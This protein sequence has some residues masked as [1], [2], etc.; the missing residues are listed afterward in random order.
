MSKTRSASIVL[1][2]ALAGTVAFAPSANAASSASAVVV[3]VCSQGSQAQL[4]ASSSGGSIAVDF[5]VSGAP[6]GHTWL[7]AIANRGT[8]VYHGAKV[9]DA[10]GSWSQSGSTRNKVGVDVVTGWAADLSTGEVCFALKTV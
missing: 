8:V 5:S 2:T 7:A 1:A 3:T 10:N 4:S 9:S 6:A